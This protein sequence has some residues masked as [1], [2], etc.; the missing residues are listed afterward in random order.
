MVLPG[1]ETLLDHPS[2]SFLICQMGVCL[3]CRVLGAIDEGIRQVFTMTRSGAGRSNDEI[4]VTL[5]VVDLS[6]AH[7]PTIPTFLNPG[8]ETSLKQLSSTS[9]VLESHPRYGRSLGLA[10]AG[11]IALQQFSLWGPVDVWVLLCHPGTP[12]TLVTSGME[13]L[14]GQRVVGLE[15]LGGASRSSPNAHPL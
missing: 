12:V 14:L 8:H 1:Y 10:G 11:S 9:Q 2:L 15:A 5:F 13:P 6:S 7:F 3:P 4:V